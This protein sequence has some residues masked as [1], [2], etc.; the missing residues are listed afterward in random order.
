MPIQRWCALGMTLLLSGCGGI[1]GSADAVW[2]SHGRQP[3][4]FV[5]PRAIAF[6]PTTR[7]I[8]VI[9]FTGRIQVFDQDGTYLRGWSTPTIVL[10]RPSG[11]GIG[12]RGE[13]LVADSHYNRVL[14]YSPDGSLLQEIVGKEGEGPGPFA[15]VSDV[16]QDETGAFYIAEFSDDRH[17]IRK[18]DSQGRYVTHWGG[19]G[20]EPGRFAR[21]RGMCFGKDG[22]L[23]V[24]DSCNH[25]IQAFD[26][27]GRFVRAF[28]EEGSEPGKLRYP[29]DVVSGTNGDLYVVEF[30]NHRVQRFSPEGQPRG[31]FG[32]PGR[33][34][35]L[36]HSPWGITVD[37]SGRVH[38][39]D[40][41]NHRIQRFRL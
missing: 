18:Y 26:R 20:S 36:L 38:V 19:Q 39:A 1:G 17:S 41:E 16:V 21:P 31:V 13:I 10:G 14:I 24:A 28:G 37:G 30:G 15:Y 33:E 32:G 4:N 6:N 40:T 22:L 9:D 35:G 5:R 34:P 7:E 29:Y 3:G 23:Y 8:V 11:V 12:L 25:R 27:Q 2:G